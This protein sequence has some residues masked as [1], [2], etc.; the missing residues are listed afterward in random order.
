MDNIFIF[1]PD[2]ATLMINTKWV[3]QQLQDNDL[4]R[5]LKPLK[6]E[7]NKLKVE[8][9]GMVIEEGKISMDPGK[10]RGIRDW[11]A[12]NYG[13]TNLRLFRIWELL[14]KIHLRLFELG[15]TTQRPIEER[16]EI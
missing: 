2:E 12:P 14:S 8:Y 9:L 4:F 11:P 7:F 15:K 13:E 3:L 6:C 5:V 10:L 1:A 16:S